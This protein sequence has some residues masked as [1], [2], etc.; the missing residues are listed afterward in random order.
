MIHVKKMISDKDL[1]DVGCSEGI[2]PLSLVS[3]AHL[4]LSSSFYEQNYLSICEILRSIYS[5]PN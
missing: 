2:F 1:K 4:N 5:K 3:I